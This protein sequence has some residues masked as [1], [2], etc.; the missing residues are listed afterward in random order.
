MPSALRSQP[1][2]Q[3]GDLRGARIDVHTVD[4]VLDDQARHVAR[5]CRLVFIGLAQWLQG[6]LGL[7]GHIERTRAVLLFP[8]PSFA[9]DLGKQIEGIQAEVHGAAGWVQQLEGARVT[10]L[11]GCL[12]R[13]VGLDQQV[14]AA[15]AQAG[16]SSGCI[17]PKPPET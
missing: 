8:G 16:S 13:F 7:G 11:G 2:R 10:Q 1:Q 17:E 15:I 14:L 6:R 9:V 3:G 4:V 5:E 12:R